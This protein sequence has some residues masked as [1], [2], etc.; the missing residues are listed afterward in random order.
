[1]LMSLGIVLSAIAAASDAQQTVQLFN[2][3]NLEN[4]YVFLKD[5]GRNNDPSK[6]FTVNDGVIH[7]SGEEMGC[8]TTMNEYSNYRLV[9]EYKWG[10]KTWAGRTGKAMDSGVLLHS[11]GEDGAFGGIWMHSIECQLIEGGTGD[12]IVVGDG[13]DNFSITVPA[14]AEK[15][16][17]CPVYKQGG[18]PVTLKSGRVNWFGRDPNWKDEKGFRGKNDVEK[19]AGEWNRYECEA[20]GSEVTTTLNGVIMNHAMDVRPNKGRIQIQSEGA[21]LF[22]RKVELI[23]L[24]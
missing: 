12:L 23:P 18:D 9:V 8:I 7:I 22:V 6:V 4:W 10:E 20:K 5:R 17:D 15:Q 21:E 13:S 24:P 1:M 14:A 3:K 16:G 2:G 19:T 11:V